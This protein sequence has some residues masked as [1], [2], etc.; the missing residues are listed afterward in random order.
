MLQVRQ[1]DATSPPAALIRS[2]SLYHKFNRTWR[3]RRS[4]GPSE[5]DPTVQKWR[6]T[7]EKRDLAERWLVRCLQQQPKDLEM[8]KDDSCGAALNSEGAAPRVVNLRRVLHRP[9][10]PQLGPVS[11]TAVND[12]ATRRALTRVVVEQHDIRAEESQRFFREKHQKRMDKL[13]DEIDRVS[14]AREA[15]RIAMHAERD[16]HVEVVAQTIG[17]DSLRP[18]EKRP[19]YVAC[20]DYCRGDGVV[21]PPASGLADTPRHVRV[22]AE[23]QTQREMRVWTDSSLG[24]LKQERLW[25]RKQHS[26]TVPQLP[27]LAVARRRVLNDDG[28]ASYWDAVNAADKMRRAVSSLN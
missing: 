13:A 27:D 24:Q 1:G 16:P 10:T 2:G 8:P 22:E 12:I 28:A 14:K 17:S 5:V 3:P 19:F 4:G 20:Y 26:S 23:K 7:R 18:I 11:M 9:A 15:I 25:R 6:A 21:C